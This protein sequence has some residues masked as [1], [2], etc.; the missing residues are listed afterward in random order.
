MPGT[1]AEALHSAA[2]RLEMVTDT[3][4]LDAE[5]LLAHALRL[6]RAQLLARPHHPLP[7]SSF[8]ALLV[9]RLQYEP[10]AYILGEWEFFSTKFRVLPPLLTPR[11]ETEH[12]VETALDYLKCNGTAADVLDV[13]CGTGCVAVCIALH[14]PTCRVYAVDIHP[15]A[16]S[17]ASY[18]ARRHGVALACFQGDLLDAFGCRES[19]FDL[20]VSNPPYVPEGEWEALSPVITR[21]EDP[22]ALLAGPDGLA[23][24]R[25]LVPAAFQALRSGG[26]LA[27]EI[28]DGQETA[29]RTLLKDAGM[30]DIAGA[31]DLAGISR[32]ISGRKP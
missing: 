13:G 21:H 10:L 7:A 1:I 4:R 20:I 28:G 25:R 15:V 19:L 14:V 32:V 22:R 11:P 8:E 29:V 18:N 9:R 24:I 3:P 2:L 26:M 12:L 27:L 5:I 16:V 30:T 23:V 17:C 6:S 31:I